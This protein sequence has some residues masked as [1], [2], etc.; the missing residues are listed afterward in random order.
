MRNSLWYPVAL[1]FIASSCFVMAF[2]LK[3]NEIYPKLTIALIIIGWIVNIA[4]IHDIIRTVRSI[5]KLH[6]KIKRLE[7][8]KAR[9]LE[10]L[11]NNQD[12]K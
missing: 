8:L 10:V 1:C 3:H 2:Y 9:Q 12:Q 11:R 6:K 4:I 5:K 7:E